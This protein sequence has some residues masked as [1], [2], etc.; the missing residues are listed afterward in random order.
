MKPALAQ[1]RERV[2]EWNAMRKDERPHQFFP[3]TY[4]RDDEGP[5]I[6]EARAE[7]MRALAIEA[8]IIPELILCEADVMDPPRPGRRIREG[9]SS[10]GPFHAMDMELAN[11][12]SCSRSRWRPA[13]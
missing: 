5:D 12:P 11:P 13:R 8:G 4:H 10:D 1:L 2:A 6:A 3:L 9:R 7:A